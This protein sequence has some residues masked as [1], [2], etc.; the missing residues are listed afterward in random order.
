[1]K[2]TCNVEDNFYSKVFN[3]VSLTRRREGGGNPSKSE[4]TDG[5]TEMR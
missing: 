5:S 1:M 4:R 3:A 2:K